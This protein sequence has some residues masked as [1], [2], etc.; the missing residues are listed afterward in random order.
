MREESAEAP[1]LIPVIS[2]STLNLCAFNIS[3]TS[4]VLVCVVFFVVLT[5]SYWPPMSIEKSNKIE[6]KCII[7]EINIDKLEKP[8]Y[9]IIK[10]KKGENRCQR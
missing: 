1:L 9:T 7:Q 5:V 2:T 10:I 4:V 8:R 3:F 6:N